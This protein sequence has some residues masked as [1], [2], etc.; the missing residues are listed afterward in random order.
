[1]KKRLLSMLL[2]LCMILTALPMASFAA[3]TNGEVP[4][5][6][7]IEF[8]V[9]QEPMTLNNSY[10][11]T[12][13]EA[14][15]ALRSEM[16]KRNESITVGLIAEN[17][18]DD[19][20]AEYANEILAYA[21]THTGVSDEGDY[22]YYNTVYVEVSAAIEPPANNGGNAFVDYIFD[23]TYLSTKS[24]EDD[25]NTKLEECY[26]SWDV[27]DADDFTQLQ[28]AYDFLN[29]GITY[30][31]PLTDD[32]AIETCRARAPLYDAAATDYAFALLVYR[33]ALDYGIDCRIVSGTVDGV[34]R[35][36][37]IVEMDGQYYHVDAALDAE[38]EKYDH[39]LK[40]SDSF[41]DH[42]LYE[43][44][45]SS[46]FQKIYPISKTDFG[47]VYDKGTV[48][49]EATCKEEGVTTYT[50]T[51]CGHEKTEVI[52]MV[53]HDY[54][55]GI[56]TKEATCE[57]EGVKTYTCTVCAHEK[58]EAI[59]V[60]DHD[61]A[62][63]VVTKEPTCAE[64]GVAT[65]TCKVCGQSYTKD[66]EMSPHTYE[67]AV[68]KEPTCTDVGELTYTCKD[69]GHSYS[70]N[71]DPT[72]HD[73]VSEVTKE[74]TCAVKGEMTYTCKTCGYTHT[75]ELEL[76]EHV[77]KSEVT[78]EPTCEK[79]GVKTFSCTSCSDYYTE[80][81]AIID[82]NFKDDVCTGCGAGAVYR[83]S[84]ASRFE[85]AYETA[86]VLKETLGLEKFK[87]IIVASG[88][89]F[90]DALTGSYLAAVRKAPIILYGDKV[91]DDNVAY[92]T[93]N[94][95]EG[96]RVCIL[97]GTNSV[98]QQ[99]DDA[100]KAEGID[101]QR[102]AGSNRFE[103]NLA[104]LEAAGV[105]D[106]EIL[107]CTADTFADSL[108]ASAAGLPILLVDNKTGTLTEGQKAFLKELDG[109][110]ITIIGGENS[111]SKTLEEA[112]GEY[113]TVDRISGGSREETSAWFADKY[114]QDPEYALVA[115]S[116]NFP[117]G[118]CGG[119]LAYAMGA[120]LL[121]AS[122]GGEDMAKAYIEYAEIIKGYVLGGAATIK[123]AS[124]RIVFNM[125]D[126]VQIMTK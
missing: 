100:L 99:L 22:L 118:L 70:S 77:Y 58:T 21:L 49:K 106:Q 48:T 56:V 55:D 110:D 72:G 57:E 85:T 115:Y 59:P 40:G 66:L 117:D 26:T 126:N 11:G 28:T 104:I 90:A 109:N 124:V 27:D 18:D 39:F 75:E 38:T 8:K 16:V 86:D 87:T 25:V 81:I 10:Y 79:E 111:V 29:K 69:C 47:H 68:T 107:V 9:S 50:C 31:G 74:S 76:L 119:P 103:T 73:Y 46:E 88:E 62:E 42:V 95:A 45:T 30:L 43:D 108:S 78:R 83:I 64:K 51:V 93:E 41:A 65:Y 53:D 97:G 24:Q 112:L 2:A 116:W 80:P 20:L 14:A 6:E 35:Y 34:E 12:T 91:L 101:V 15:D 7:I 71:I 60:V 52:P 5:G 67:S 89:N 94:L 3:E 98:S 96:G 44:Y 33:F 36:W 121:L 123:D 37:N 114:F 1:M 13:S 32:T 125:K 23:F 113:G 4:R 92:I 82:H 102:F 120:P 105:T 122:E 63:G 19:S 17:Y 61:Y 84:G 54:A